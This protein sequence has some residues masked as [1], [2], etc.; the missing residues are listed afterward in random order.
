MDNTAME[1]E[2]VEAALAFLV[3]AHREQAELLVLT[4]VVAEALAAAFS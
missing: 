2:A 1:R 4:M 3:K